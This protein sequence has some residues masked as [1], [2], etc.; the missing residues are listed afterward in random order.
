[1]IEGARNSR[2]IS[3]EPKR[4]SAGVAMS[5]CTPMAMGTPP[6]WVAPSSSAIASAQ[7]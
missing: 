7:E 2:F 1:V 5:V 3:S 4:A 6:Q